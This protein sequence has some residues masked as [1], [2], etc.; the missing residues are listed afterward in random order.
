MDF[1]LLQDLVDET[2]STVRFFTSFADFTASPLP[3]TLDE[4]RGYRERA[5]EFIGARNHRIASH[6][7]SAAKPQA[8]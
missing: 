4:Y 7:P 1:F 8:P 2:A 3:G 6:H 5:M